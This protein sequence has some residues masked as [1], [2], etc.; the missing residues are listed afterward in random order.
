M[1]NLIKIL[2]NDKQTDIKQRTL[3]IQLYLYNPFLY[4]KR[5]FDIRCYDLMTSVNGF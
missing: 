5:K 3:I 4:C 1:N 2:K